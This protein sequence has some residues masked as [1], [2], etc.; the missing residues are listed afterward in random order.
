MIMR[1]VNCALV[2]ALLLTLFSNTQAFADT[3]YS[4]SVNW[5]GYVATG[6]TFNKVHGDITVPTVT[7]TSP[8]AQVLFWVGLDG[9]SNST[10]EQVGVGAQCNGTNTPTYFG[11]WEMINGNSG[12]EIHKIPSTQLKVV[13][14]NT[15]NCV[16]AA[17]PNSDYFNL[18]LYNSTTKEKATNLLEGGY[19]T[20][21]QTAEWIAERP[22]VNG[23]QYA[24]LARWSNVPT[25]FTAA[26]YTTATSNVITPMTNANLISLYMISA[27]T[28]WHQLDSVQNIWANGQTF[29]A[30]WSATL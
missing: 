13:P 29:Q 28:N 27:K 8:T 1:I 12:N 14:G 24:P 23:N 18:Q 21:R 4:N 11:W 10:L 22:I 7:C 17:I 3:S 25:L 2:S 6:N 5:S 9:F 19:A 30:S 20:Q 15:I 26:N 16:V